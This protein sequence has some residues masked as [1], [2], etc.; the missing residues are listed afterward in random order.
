MAAHTHSLHPGH[1]GHAWRLWLAEIA[2]VILACL[3]L[4][5]GVFYWRQGEIVQGLLV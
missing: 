3:G 4:Y 5:F 2:I 1:A